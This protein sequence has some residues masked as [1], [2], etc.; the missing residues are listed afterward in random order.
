DP[1]LNP[2]PCGPG[3][4]T[5]SNDDYRSVTGDGVTDGGGN[6]SGTPVFVNGTVGMGQDFHLVAGSPGI[7]G[8][9]TVPVGDTALDGVMRPMG[10]GPDMGAYEYVP[11]AGS[12]GG[13]GLTGGTGST[14]GKGAS[15]GGTGTTGD[16]G[17]TGRVFN[18][19][20]AGCVVPKLKGKTLARARRALSAAHCTLGR[21]RKPKHSSGTLVVVAQGLK[22]GTKSETG[23]MVAVKLAPQ[24]IHRPH[25]KRRHHRR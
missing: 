5:A 19:G 9:A 23:T 16:T 13:T 25:K 8:G 10:G 4:I 21:V 15:G 22:A 14:G 1:L 17:T 3:T 7:D 6:I 20:S 18:G 12:T 11:P 24:P 2:A